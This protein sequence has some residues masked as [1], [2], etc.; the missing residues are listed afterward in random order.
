MFSPTEFAKPPGP[1][2]LVLFSEQMP[3]TDC[4]RV[5][6]RQF[7]HILYLNDINVRLVV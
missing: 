2:N 7:F 6:T 3:N 4:A 1:A 5:S